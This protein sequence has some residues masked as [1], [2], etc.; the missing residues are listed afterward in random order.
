MAQDQPPQPAAV[1]PSVPS[2]RNPLR[3]LA[4]EA[5]PDGLIWLAT[6]GLPHPEAGRA[7]ALPFIFEI[8]R[9]KQADKMHTVREVEL[10]IAATT[11]DQRDHASLLRQLEAYARFVV[12]TNPTRHARLSGRTLA[13]YISTRKP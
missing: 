2:V 5:V 9:I 10:V 1:S 4:Q 12:T 6:E 13:A 7:K 11:E 8:G 3:A